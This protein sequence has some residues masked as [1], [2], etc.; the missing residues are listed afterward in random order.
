MTAIPF[1]RDDGGRAAAGLRGDAG[2]CVTRAIAIAAEL[3]YRQV[4]EALR[5][6]A[7]RRPNMARLDL[8][9][10]A[11]ARRHASPRDGVPDRVYRAYLERLGWEWTPTMTFGEGCSTHLRADELA[12]LGDRLICKVS[13]HLCAVVDGQLRDTSDCSRGGTRCVYGVYRRVEK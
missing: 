11:R 10:G 3:P 6:E 13:K 9:Y 2:D 4:Y 8:R 1:V 12:P 7:H 5:N